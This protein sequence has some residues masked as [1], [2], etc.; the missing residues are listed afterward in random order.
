MH[1][2]PGLPNAL[3]S[4]QIVILQALTQDSPQQDQIVRVRSDGCYTETMPLNTNEVVLV[5]PEFATG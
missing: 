3:S 1:I 2:P 4:A 5:T